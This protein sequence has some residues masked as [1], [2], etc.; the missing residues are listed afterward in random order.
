MT[1][2]RTVV[3]PATLEDVPAIRAILAAHGNDGP[4]TRVD[5]IGPYLRY[6]VTRHRV[7]LAEESG[8]A[9]AFGAVLDTGLAVHLAD[10]FV[11]PER[12]GQGLGGP[13]LAALYGGAPRRTTFASDDPRALPLYVRAGMMPLWPCLYLEGDGGHLS[14]A[15]DLDLASVA[16]EELASLELAWTGAARADD[17]RFWA[18]QADADPFLVAD[19]D[20]PVAL[21]IGRARQASEARVVDRLLIRPGADPVAPVLASLRR[22]A[23]GGAVIA[24]L[25][26]PSP[27]LPV[28]LDHGF[29]VVDRDVYMASDP[30]LVDPARFIPNPGML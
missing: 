24:S 18:S 1:A 30:G 6:L 20:G 22:T 28:L 8:A 14:G 7:L 11:V 25:L 2:A 3:R 29:R 9:V 21:A 4:I 23:R 19:R 27:V 26:G 10:L 16:P 15:S 12:L 13:L 17:H 5:I